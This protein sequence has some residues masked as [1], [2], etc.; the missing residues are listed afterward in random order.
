VGTQP[1]PTTQGLSLVRVL[2]YHRDVLLFWLALAI[3]IAGLVAGVAYAVVYG[4]RAW[5]DL[6]ATGSLIS[7]QLD[8]VAQA[9]TEIEKHLDRAAASSAPATVTR[10]VPFLPPR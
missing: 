10:A 6:K 8:E 4:L 7:G 3:A 5:R 2:D 9:T 1:A